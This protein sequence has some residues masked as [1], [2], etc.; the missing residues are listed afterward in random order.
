MMSTVPDVTA[1]I[2]RAFRKACTEI[3]RRVQAGETCVVAELLQAPLTLDPE[4]ATELI[5]TEFV[6]RE[7]FGQTPQPQEY[8]TRFP[9]HAER[10]KRL[11]DV[12]QLLQADERQGDRPTTAKCMGAYELRERL[13]AGAMGVVY[14]GYHPVLQR[15]VAIKVLALPDHPDGDARFVREGRASAGLNHPHIVQL[16]EVGTEEGQPYL[17]MEYVA[18][19][20]LREHLAGRWLPPREAAQLCATVAHAVQHAH[21]QAILHRDLKP[22]N[23]LLKPVVPGEPLFPKVSD[24]GLATRLDRH[25]DS[26]T[27]N[28]AGTPGYMAPEQASA[29]QPL[30]AAADVYALGAVLY[31]TLV[32]RPPFLGDSPS[33]TLLKLLH[34]DPLPPRRLRAD[35]PRDLETICLKCLH[36]T[37]SRRYATASDLAADLEAYIEGRPIRARRVSLSERLWKFARRRPV[38]TSTLLLAF[39]AFAVVVVGWVEFTRQLGNAVHAKQQ[40][41]V[42]ANA[43]RHEADQQRLDA[44]RERRKALELLRTS[45]EY[46]YAARLLQVG[47]MLPAEPNRAMTLLEADDWCPPERRDFAWHYLHASSQPERFRA[48]LPLEGVNALA[49][50][51]DGHFAIAGGMNGTL[52]G[53]DP[54]DGKVLFTLPKAHASAITGLAVLPDGQ[55]FVGASL[56]GTVR[57]WQR[58][59][60]SVRQELGKVD[61][62][63][64]TLGMAP[65]G[66]AVFVGGGTRAVGRIAAWSLPQGEVRPTPI[67][68]KSLLRSLAFAPE[69]AILTIGYESGTLVQY[70][71]RRNEPIARFNTTMQRPQGLSVRS[72]GLI[73]LVSPHHRRVE[74]WDGITKQKVRTVPLVLGSW[75]VQF[76]PDGQT[77]ATTD[78]TDTVNLY[79]CSNG[80][81]LAKYHG[82]MRNNPEARATV[83]NETLLP[84]QANAI[85]SFSYLSEQ[86][87]LSA[88]ADGTI[89]GWALDPR[90]ESLTTTVPKVE[91]R[92]LL[93]PPNR[94]LAYSAGEDRRLYAIDLRTGEATAKTDPLPGRLG[95]FVLQADGKHLVSTTYGTTIKAKVQAPLHLQ[96]WSLPD[97]TP[98]GHAELFEPSLQSVAGPDGVWLLA[99]EGN[100]YYWPNDSHEPPVLL[101]THDGRVRGMA[102]WA[103]GKCLLTF[104]KDRVCT[105]TTTGPGESL[106]PRFPGTVSHAKASPQGDIIFVVTTELPA[107][108]ITLQWWNP[109]TNEQRILTG[110]R[111]GFME[112]VWSADQHTLALTAP[113]RKITLVH[114]TS[115]EQ[116]LALPESPEFVRGMCFTPDGR[117]LVVVRLQPS[118]GTTLIQRWGTFTAR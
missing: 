98:A 106:T 96:R 43:E 117:T 57:L 10:L 8:L 110:S 54:R 59:K 118:T 36:K 69:G 108:R 61:F 45:R 79:R 40:A 30:T 109:T 72:D 116:L 58:T 68:E 49:V 33:E 50:S 90:P 5:F 64:Y 62:P 52:C 25:A 74:L 26:R 9:E 28:L 112:G 14:R 17:V 95:S 77:F 24:F 75:S 94:W 60:P 89:R 18:G 38:L 92:G 78:E 97:C 63:I 76:G 70:D 73:A 31:E 16:Y 83:L 7:A 81:R 65:D 20:T 23:I 34:D 71:L 84:G 107:N 93:V 55:S 87:V 47:T 67:P 12:D 113:D 15:E 111:T 44:D 35:V 99:N 80:V 115:G 22:A 19:G 102:Y 100:V 29:D 39:L 104:P 42:T 4:V 56:D 32:G 2:E 114:T 101:G 86:R 21:E 3:N 46:Q 41:L 6:T 66:T 88:S 53:L 105:W 82:H 13:G 51:K 85:H 37:P 103:A 11:F 91:L 27:A 1:T 48:T